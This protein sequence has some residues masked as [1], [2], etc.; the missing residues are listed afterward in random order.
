[1]INDFS[2]LLGRGIISARTGRN[3]DALRYL[4]L[5]VEISPGH[6]RAWLWLAAA[7]ETLPEKRRYLQRV[8]QIDPQHL[9]ARALLGRLAP[10]AAEDRVRPAAEVDVFHCSHCGGKQRFDPD[11]LGL[12]CEYCR[13]IERLDHESEAALPDTA[14]LEQKMKNWS[15]FDNRV[16]CE[17]CGAQITIPSDSSTCTCPFCDS[18][19]VLVQPATPDLIAPMAVIPFRFHAGDLQKA[20]SQRWNLAPDEFLDLINRR[21]MTLTPIYLP[22]WFFSGQVQICCMLNYRVPEREYSNTERVIRKHDDWSGERTWFETEVEDL[23]VYAGQAVAEAALKQIFPFEMSGLLD[24]QPEFLAGWRSEC[25]QIA[26]EDA[27]ITAYKQMRDTAFQRAA[28]RLLFIEP[29]KMLQND[30]LINRKTFLLA[31]LPVWIIRRRWKGKWFQTLVNGQTG[32][33]TGPQKR[34]WLEFLN[35]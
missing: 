11:R 21:E 18:E 4:S 30:V 17:A 16:L 15:V 13:Q 24:Y 12:V 1:M 22:F 31:L 23:W 14:D 2:E 20:V 34:R 6:I 28:R 8:L 26:L 5:A 9:M 27:G 3:E 29:S 7:A 25:Y 19:H 10:A 35:W 33:I 32:K